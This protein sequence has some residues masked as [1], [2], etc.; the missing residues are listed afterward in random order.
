[1]RATLILVIFCILAPAHPLAQ[2]PGGQ[3]AT[4]QEPQQARHTLRGRVYLPNGQMV[5]NYV[6]LTLRL[7]T[8]EIVRESHTDS[9]GSF[10]FKN[11]SSGDYELVMWGTDDFDTTIEKIELYGNRSYT[12]VREIRLRK[13]EADRWER[14]KAGVVS[15]SELDRSIPKSARREYERGIKESINGQREKAMAHFQRAIEIHDHFVQ[16]HNDLGVQYLRLGRWD[17]ARTALTKAISL[18]PRLVYPYL[19]L[20]YVQIQ[21]H[22]YE[23]AVL[24]LN[25]AVEL[26]TTDWRGH[27]WLGVG[28]METKNETLAEQELTT[29]LQLSQPPEGSITHLYLANLYIRRGDLARAIDHGQAYLQEVPNAEN[30]QEVREKIDRMR[31]QQ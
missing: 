16:A 27:L 19:N 9:S 3:T 25:R 28:L 23:D 17:E 22:Q 6:R 24:S 31:T 1:M 10:E 15:L 4:D 7:S 13:K 11:L 12:E 20:G 21:Q 5:E 2:Q 18:E 8:Q 30:A 26:D 14:P 29:A